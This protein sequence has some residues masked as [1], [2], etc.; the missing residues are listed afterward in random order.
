MNMQA[1]I[2]YEPFLVYKPG[3]QFR[4]S[5][6]YLRRQATPK[7]GADLRQPEVCRS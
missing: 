1:S 7:G 2:Q 3:K 4:S 6:R 5:N